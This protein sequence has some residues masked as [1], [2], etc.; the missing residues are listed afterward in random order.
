MIAQL[1]ISLSKASAQ[2]GALPKVL[3]I[4]NISLHDSPA[5]MPEK[6]AKVLQ[7]S[8]FGWCL[9]I[10]Q[11]MYKTD[12]SLLF[13]CQLII[14]NSLVGHRD[15]LGKGHSSATGIGITVFQATCSYNLGLQ[16]LL[17]PDYEYINSI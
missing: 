12:P 6:W 11:N 17:R 1:T 7:L 3:P 15:R 4:E 10:V 13:L 8:T 16:Y 9:Q 2:L 5:V 14:G